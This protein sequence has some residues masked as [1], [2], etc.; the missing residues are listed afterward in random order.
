MNTHLRRIDKQ[1]YFRIEEYLFLFLIIRCRVISERRA[2]PCERVVVPL[3][4]GSSRRRSGRPRLGLQNKFLRSVGARRP[5]SSSPIDPTLLRNSSHYAGRF[6]YVYAGAC[7]DFCRLRSG[8]PQVN[9][10]PQQIAP[11]KRSARIYLD[12]DEER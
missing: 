6:Q 4:G 12:Q 2:T 1:V 7:L 8:L 3:C 9:H 10:R 11:D 5:R